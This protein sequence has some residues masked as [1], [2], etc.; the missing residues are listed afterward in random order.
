MISENPII[1]ITSKP[2]RFEIKFQDSEILINLMSL[3][4]WF[5]GILFER[6]MTKVLQHNQSISNVMN[7]YN[8]LLFCQS[9]T[10]LLS[11]WD[12]TKSFTV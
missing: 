6:D 4:Q 1:L 8:F 12:A 10:G 5:T 2:S 7:C 9:I 11:K 3:C